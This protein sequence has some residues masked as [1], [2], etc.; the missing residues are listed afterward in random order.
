VVTG[1]S[2]TDAAVSAEIVIVAT[3]YAGHA[4]LVVSMAQALDGRIAV[5]CVNPLGFDK[6]GAYGLDVP[7]GSA[8]EELQS[9][10]PGAGRRSLPPPRGGEPVGRRR[11]AGRGGRLGV[12]GRPAAKDEVIALV[13]DVTGRAGVDA[14]PRVAR[15]L[16][17]WTAVLIGVN[18]RYRVRSGLRLVGLG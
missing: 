2:N 7:A 6:R 10:A 12:R 16:E 11:G 18:R 17:P 15:Q 5:S 3:P 13:P 8:A 1:A 9:L 14:G 4:E